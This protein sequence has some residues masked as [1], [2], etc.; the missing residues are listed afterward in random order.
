MIYSNQFDNLPAKDYIPTQNKTTTSS[1]M[2]TNPMLEKA[3][4]FVQDKELQFISY[5]KRF[6]IDYENDYD[7]AVLRYYQAHLRSMRK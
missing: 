5:C 4:D 1:K 6:G 2:V 3:Y 7:N